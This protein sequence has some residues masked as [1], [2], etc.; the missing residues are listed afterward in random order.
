[1]NKNFFHSLKPDS[2]NKSEH[3]RSFLKSI[4]LGGV[5]MGFFMT[6]EAYA[7]EVEFATQ[8]VSRA[9]SPSELKITD[10]RITK[11][12]KTP[13]I[14]IY[15]NQGIYGL[16][17]VRDDASEVYALFLKSR[18]LGKNPCNVEMIFMN[19]KQFGGHG[20]K[21]GGVCGIE[22]ALWDLAGKAFNVP[23]YQMLGG[24]YRDKIRIYTLSPGTGSG[25]ESIGENIKSRMAEGFTFA[26][27][28][29]TPAILKDVPNAIV[30]GNNWDYTK[31]YNPDWASYGQTLHPFTRMQLTP[32]GINYLSD[33]VGKIRDIAGYEIPIG[34]DHLG[35]FEHNS[36]IKLGKALDK[37]TLAFLEDL[38]P[39]MFPEQLKEI[40]NA[41][42]TP[43]MTGEDIYLKEEFIKLCDN[44]IV[45]MVQPDLA[46][47]GGILET[48]KIGDYAEERGLPMFLH[49]AG[50]PVSLMANVHSA[51]ATGN[52]IA[53]EG[54]FGKGFDDLVTGISKPIV[55]KG[56]IK[57][58]ESPG[59]GIDLDEEVLKSRL[60]E[61]QTLFPPSDEWN[62]E[63]SWDRTWS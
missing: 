2:T 44:H 46:S 20:R 4:A 38:Q 36:L 10:L 49:F 59:L 16:G 24:R 42:E 26:K 39:W 17:E 8:N 21:A 63:S 15:T 28:H 55:D 60:K 19:I 43:T 47:S 52:F 45:D 50:T 53:L 57:V 40:T 22:M 48:K 1:M 13:L 6:R 51:A 14:K 37:Y 56:F 33:Y 7:E 62:T 61:G 34:I 5:G 32:T 3:R 27:I 23:V 31:P 29:L 9:S 41:I 54:R 30:G 35:H 25:P 18:I 12:G 58:P 11:L